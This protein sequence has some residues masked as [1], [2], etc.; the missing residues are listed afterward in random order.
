[1]NASRIGSE[2]P[3]SAEALSLAIENL[4][5]AFAVAHIGTSIEALE[6]CVAE[7]RKTREELVNALAAE[8]EKDASGRER[9]I[10]EFSLSLRHELDH[11]LGPRAGEAVARGLGKTLR[12]GDLKSIVRS[13]P[14]LAKKIHGP[15]GVF[16]AARRKTAQHNARLIQA[17]ADDG[18]ESIDAFKM[19]ENLQASRAEAQSALEKLN[20]AC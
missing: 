7:G 18:I 16:L 19:I 6:R 5:L 10:R 15:L 14:G 1:M 8:L 12:S 4:V 17:I 11:L 9:F 13:L 2:G 3:V 20:A